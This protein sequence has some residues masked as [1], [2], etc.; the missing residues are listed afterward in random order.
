MKRMLMVLLLV[1][2]LSMAQQKGFL[3]NGSL[4]G[5]KNNSLVSLTDANNPSDTL[6]KSIVTNNTFQLKGQ[7]PEPGLLSL[8]FSDAQKK[9]LLFLDNSTVSI[10]GNAAEIQ[11]VKVEGSPTHKDFVDF[12]VTFTPLF[13]KLNQLGD[14][15]KMTGMTDNLS[16]QSDKITKEIQSAVDKFLLDRKGSYVTPF[17]VMVTAQLSDNAQLLETRFNDLA[18][19]VKKGFYGKYVKEI[20]DNNKIGAVGSDAIEFTQ[21]DPD[22]KPISLA[23]FRG[24]YVLIDFWASWCGPCRQEN[25]NVVNTYKKFKDR[26]FTVLGISLDKTRDPWLKAIKDDNLTWT[27]VSDLKFWNNEVAQKYKVQGIPKNYLIDP[28]GKIIAR[29]LRGPLLAQRLDELLK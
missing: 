20:V 22:G 14:Q 2:F 5:I 13:T 29:D 25:P 12:Q 17:L 21:N 7:L 23:S 24:K 15:I 27:H 1:P 4:S 26:N 6:A 3:I 9:T 18:E 10:S 16:I 19:N 8:N 28:K 11:K